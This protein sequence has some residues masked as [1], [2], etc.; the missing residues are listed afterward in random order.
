MPMT[1]RQLIQELQ[2]RSDEEL[3]A[4]I[5]LPEGSRFRSIEDVYVAEFYGDTY[6][7]IRPA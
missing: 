3:D 4:E 1:A 7:V 6:M 5:V 2:Q